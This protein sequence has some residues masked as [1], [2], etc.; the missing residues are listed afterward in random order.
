[1]K[2]ILILMM[3]FLLPTGCFNKNNNEIKEKIINEIDEIRVED[4]NEYKDLIVFNDT[5]IES[6]IGL[7][8]NDLETYIGKYSYPLDSK[9]YLIVKTKNKEKIKNTLNIYISN[10]KERIKFD[11]NINSEIIL[12]ENEFINKKIEMLNNV[13]IEEYNGYLIFISSNNN[14]EVLSIIKENLK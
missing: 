10:L 11:N 14:E 6:E 13:T 2:K 4:V 9:F 8:I 5:T 7:D 3:L 1:M 12:E